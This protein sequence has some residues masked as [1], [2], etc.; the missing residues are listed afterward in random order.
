ESR[1]QKAE[2][3][4]QSTRGCLLPSAFCLLPVGALLALSVVACWAQLGPWQTAT[5]Q[6]AEINEELLRVVP[7]QPRSA[8]M[9][10]Y[11]ENLPDSY[12]G[13][14]VH[15]IGLGV[16]RDF[17]N[18]DGPQVRITQHA[19]QVDLVAERRDVFALRF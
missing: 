18:R 1:R 2:G 17:T 3:S 6:V 15:R 13:A 7:P 10:W 9:L 16:I 14:Y 8:R 5:A 12:E 4:R 11:V 19:G